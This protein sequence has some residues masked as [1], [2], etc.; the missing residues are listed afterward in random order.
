MPTHDYFPGI[1]FDIQGP[2]ET[3]FKFLKKYELSITRGTGS[4]V[5]LNLCVEIDN[6]R[7]LEDPTTPIEDSEM[8]KKG[9][10]PF[11]TGSLSIIDLADPM[12]LNNKIKDHAMLFSSPVKVKG[13]KIGGAGN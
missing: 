11:Q 3:E 4:I 7:I 5:Q 6:V 1:V 10:L 12:K 9:Y 13:G 2:P 8:E